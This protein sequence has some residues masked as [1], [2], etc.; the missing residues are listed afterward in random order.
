MHDAKKTNIVPI[1]IKWLLDIGADFHR[2]CYGNFFTCDDQKGSRRDNKNY[3]V[4]S[5]PPRRQ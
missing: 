4:N 5:L 1:P 3:E 2:R